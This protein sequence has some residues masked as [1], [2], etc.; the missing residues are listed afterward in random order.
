MILNCKEFDIN[1][2]LIA[3]GNTPINNA[4]VN[5][6]IEIFKTEPVDKRLRFFSILQINRFLKEKKTKAFIV[7]KPNEIFIG[8]MI[9]ILSGLKLKIIY[10]QQVSLNFKKHRLLYSFLFNWV[11]RW[12]TPV[13]YIRKEAIEQKWSWRKDIEVI[14]HSL[15]LTSYSKNHLKK[16]KARDNLDLPVDKKMIGILGR[17]NPRKNQDFLIR[18]IN[19]LKINNYDLDL[20]IMGE[21]KTED[22]QVYS[23]FLRELMI[24]C[25][26][27]NRVHF[28]TFSAKSITFFRAIDVFI[29][30]TTG[31]TCDVTMIESMAAG[32]PV[33]AI[34]SEYNSEILDKGNL[35][36]LYK[37]NDIED[38]SAKIIKLF[39]YSKLY[40]FLQNEGRKAAFEK[41]DLKSK[42]YK[43]EE[44]IFG[45]LNQE[46]LLRK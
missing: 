20:F 23:G 8:T 5:M 7:T 26:L 17:H 19:F 24:E 33:L 27:Q 2:I 3:S 1:T 14:P 36:I 30:T 4:L 46:R 16:D 32:T 42:C 35:G 40:V 10:Y 21:P 41:Y 12:I 28:R 39:N 44:L 9:K 38:F 25:D 22:E 29:M 15:N 31:E 43:F 13:D 45:L 6:G 11:D 18:A 34:Q 37:E